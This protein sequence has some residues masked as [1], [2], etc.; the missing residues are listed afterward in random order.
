MMKKY[1]ILW[2]TDYCDNFSE[3]SGETIIEAEN[4]EDAKQKFYKGT[5]SKAIIF[6]IQE[7]WRIGGL[8]VYEEDLKILDAQIE[9]AKKQLNRKGLSVWQTYELERRLKIYQDMR[10]DLLIQ[11]QNYKE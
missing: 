8:I 2:E 10:L 7:I 9:R 5:L 11:I 6:D 1:L 3:L 4:E